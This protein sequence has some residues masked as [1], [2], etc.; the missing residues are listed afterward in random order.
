MIGVTRGFFKRFD[1]KKYWYANSFFADD[2]D[3]SF[4][5]F[6]CSYSVFT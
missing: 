1:E 4:V 2:F 5:Y 3:V 6:K